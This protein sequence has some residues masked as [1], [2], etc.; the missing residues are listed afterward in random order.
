MDET[1][2]NHDYPLTV[3]AQLGDAVHYLYTIEAKMASINKSS[4]LH[5]VV[6]YTVSAINQANL[7]AML[8]PVLSELELDLIR[9]ARNFR[10][11]K[12]TKIK[13]SVYRMATAFE[14]LYGYLYLNDKHRL[15]Y[16]NDLCQNFEGSTD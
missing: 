13:Q 2:F 5:D 7:L 15:N 1:G 3:L 16:L 8:K 9:R 12:K 10:S 11:I 4:Q 6:A 14:V